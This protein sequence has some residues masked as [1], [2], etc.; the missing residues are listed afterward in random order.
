MEKIFL[1]QGH[2]THYPLINFDVL[3]SLTK[4]QS[5]RQGKPAI[6]ALRLRQEDYLKL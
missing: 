2:V 3:A 1:S 5:N 4:K 6:P